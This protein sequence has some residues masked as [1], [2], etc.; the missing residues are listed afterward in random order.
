[1]KNAQNKPPITVPNK[2]RH[3]GGEMVRAEQFFG[4]ESL[5]LPIHEYKGAPDAT[6]N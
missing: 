2:G 1:M 3:M 6:S 5:H 4:G